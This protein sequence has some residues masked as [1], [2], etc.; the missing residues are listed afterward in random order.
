MTL[1]KHKKAVLASAAVCIILIWCLTAASCTVRP[2]QCMFADSGSVQSKGLSLKPK[3]LT[4][5]KRVKDTGAP[6]EA[7]LGRYNGGKSS[8]L[9]NKSKL[10]LKS[11]G[12]DINKIDDNIEIYKDNSLNK[13]IYRAKIDNSQ[14]DVDK[15]GNIA[16]FTNYNDFSTE[17][18]NRHDYKN[19]EN[20]PLPKVKYKLNSADDLKQII[21]N[22]TE[23]NGLQGYKLDECNN[24]IEGAWQLVWHKDIGNGITNPNDVYTASIDARDGSVMIFGRNTVLPNT[25]TPIVTKDEAIKFA[26]PVIN[27]FKDAKKI[28]AALTVTRPNFYWDTG[29]PYER[30]DF[31]RLAWEVKIDSNACAMVDAETGEILGGSS[32]GITKISIKNNMKK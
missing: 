6:F 19:H 7:D 15:D 29:G 3:I 17:G 24:D 11:L 18:K 31:A 8:L 13:I 27:K 20:E 2:K 32:Y 12:V 9:N 30:A 4:D 16:G 10:I 5:Y 22:L 21:S 23:I 1:N 26:Q 25:N 14:V 28:D